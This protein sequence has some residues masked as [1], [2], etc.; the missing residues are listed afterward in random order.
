MF[1]PL[2]C[3]V[4]QIISP[5]RLAVSVL[6]FVFFFHFTHCTELAN[7]SFAHHGCS[8]YWC[9]Q[10]SY[11]LLCFV[12]VDFNRDKLSYIRKGHIDLFYP[13][14]IFDMSYSVY[15][16]SFHLQETQKLIFQTPNWGSFHWALLALHP[17]VAKGWNREGSLSLIGLGWSYNCEDRF[18]AT[19]HLFFFI[20]FTCNA[21]Y[22]IYFDVLKDILYPDLSYNVY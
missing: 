11:I 18:P 10:D 7:Y 6:N 8:L 3:S 17:L 21:H 22:I 14:F 5:V 9:W 1:L 15:S 2:Y 20:C 12:W 13:H 4:R 16:K 19:F